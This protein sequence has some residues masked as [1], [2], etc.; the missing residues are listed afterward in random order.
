MVKDPAESFDY[1]AWVQ[2]ALLRVVHRSLTAVAEH[3]LTGAHHFYITFATDSPGVMVARPLLERYPDE[4]TI[5]IQ[6]DYRDLE[7]DDEGFSVTLRFSGVP[8]RLA[9]PFLAIR[10]FVDPSAQFGLRFDA[11]L[12]GQPPEDQPPPPPPA[13]GGDNVV[14]FPNRFR[15]KK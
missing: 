1:A 8:Y 2:Q 12:L 7:V 11:E 10:S 13:T 9:I 4:M 6:N 15:K 3:G 5:V 14:S